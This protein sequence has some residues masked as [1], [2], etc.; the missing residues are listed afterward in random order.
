MH[1]DNVADHGDWKT[2][3]DHVSFEG[4]LGV[5]MTLQFTWYGLRLGAGR[6]PGP[7]PGPADRP[8]PRG[9]RTGPQSALGFFFKDP[10]ASDEHR[11]AAQWD[12]L[13]AWCGSG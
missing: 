7:R 13:V 2:A 3:M 5:R 8:R 10:A 9:G 6:A 4:F 12:A 1:I 11:L